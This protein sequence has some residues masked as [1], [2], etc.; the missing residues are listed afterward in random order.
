[1]NEVRLLSAT[2]LAMIA[3]V[4]VGP[5]HAASGAPLTQAQ[6]VTRFAKATGH[7]LEVDRASSRAGRYT[8]LRLSA[9]VTNTAT[10]GDFRL[11]LLPQ[12]ATD[13]DTEQLLMNLHTGELGTPAA[14]GVY[15]EQTRLLGGG[16]VW[17]G[18]KRYGRNLVLWHYGPV[19]KVDATFRRLHLALLRVAS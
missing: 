19:H 7:R 17:L 11:Y 9:S 15:W 14:G 5:G 2:V 1:V 18:K 16:T 4:V 3:L 8:V 6:V 12:G 10:Y 13:A